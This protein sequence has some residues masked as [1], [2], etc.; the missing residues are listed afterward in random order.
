[1]LH[2]Y[3]LWWWWHILYTDIWWCDAYSTMIVM[4]MIP[5]KHYDDACKQSTVLTSSTA[6]TSLMS[7]TAVVTQWLVS[8]FFT[9]IYTVQVLTVFGV[10]CKHTYTTQVWDL[11]M[12]Y[13]VWSC[14]LSDDDDVYLMHTWCKLW[15][16]GWCWILS[17]NAQSKLNTS[18]RLTTL[19]LPQVMWHGVKLFDCVLVSSNWDT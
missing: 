18:P 19:I 4:L 7:S 13:K 11:D 17:L 14:I 1:M 6:V 8:G 10:I 15:W 3:V 9:S 2:F 16:R 12:H 5:C